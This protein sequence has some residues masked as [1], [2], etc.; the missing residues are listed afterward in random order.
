MKDRSP[1][2]QTQRR[3]EVCPGGDYD[4]CVLGRVFG[5]LGVCSFLLCVAE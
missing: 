2:I 1:D 5:H 4:Y 3:A